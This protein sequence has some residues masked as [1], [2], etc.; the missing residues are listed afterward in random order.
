MRRGQHYGTILVDLEQRRVVDLL[1]DRTAATLTSWLK[2]HPSVVITARDRSLEYALGIKEGAPG[3]IQVAD[4]WHLL[5]N[6]GEVVEKHSRNCIPP[7]RNR[8]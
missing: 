2:E 6:L 5:K 3:A 4:R 8:S 7:S 1:S